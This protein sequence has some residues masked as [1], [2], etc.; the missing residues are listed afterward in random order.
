[1]DQQSIP[2]PSIYVPD[3]YDFVFGDEFKAVGLDESR[4][5][6][7]YLHLASY[8]AGV[9]SEMSVAQPGDGLLHLSTSYEDGQFLTGMIRS[10]DEFQYG[11]FEARIQF[12]RLQGHHGA[13]WLQSH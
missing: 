5:E 2:E 4:W 3:G 9:L 10:V 12:Q 11:Y 7:R 1:L 13:F 6:Y 8:G